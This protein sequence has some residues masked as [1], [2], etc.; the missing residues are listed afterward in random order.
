MKTQKKYLNF[1]NKL[2]NQGIL[3]N[4]CYKCGSGPI[5]NNKPLNLHLDHINGNHSDNTLENLRILCPN[6][7]S[8]TDN[9]CGKNKKSHIKN[10]DKIIQQ[11]L[12]C[13][14][15]K[16]KPNC[17]QCGK[18][19]SIG[20]RKCK[21]CA[22]MESA[23]NKITWPSINELKELLKTY[24]YT[25]LAKILGVSDNAIRK[26][27][28]NRREELPVSIYDNRPKDKRSSK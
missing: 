19:I 21:S 23:K 4:E 22:K 27:I 14:I 25:Q 1:K 6:C 24:N 18:E 13:K 9:F 3:K 5:Y 15:P 12:K 26:R 2:I 8:Q 20:S 11:D 10:K 16:Q 7:H 17:K 28:K